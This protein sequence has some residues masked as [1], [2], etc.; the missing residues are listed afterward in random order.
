MSKYYEVTVIIHKTYAVEVEDDE[1]LDH[2]V[3][4][5][6]DEVFD[7]FDV[8]DTAG[9]VVDDREISNM[10]ALADEVIK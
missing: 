7:D 2:A 5:V 4:Y 9:P 10:K 6:N 8:I 1:N 3:A